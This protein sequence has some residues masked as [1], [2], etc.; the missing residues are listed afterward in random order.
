MPA[1]QEWVERFP[2]SGLKWFFIT[3]NVIAE[4]KDEK[5]L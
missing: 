5:S 4:E 2:V 3:I 1:N